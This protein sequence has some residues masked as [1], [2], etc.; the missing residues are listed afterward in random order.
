MQI[1]TTARHF[2]LDPDDRRHIIERV[3]K[4]SKFARDI[5]EVH[6]VVTAENYRH[7]AEITLKLK[8]RDM[9]SKE[10][11][12]EPR[13]GFD[14]AADR[15]ETQLRR[16]KEYRVALHRGRVT[17]GK[18]PDVEQ[19]PVRTDDDFSEFGEE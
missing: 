4:L 12:T 17:N 10:E 15:I 3:E 1:H 9:V 6:V 8:R 2:E 5:H 18:E 16:L 7:V 14:L 19:V 13:V 11:S